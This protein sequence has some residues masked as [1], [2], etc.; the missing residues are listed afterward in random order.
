MTD[1]RGSSGAEKKKAGKPKGALSVRY[2]TPKEMKTAWE[3]ES[4]TLAELWDLHPTTSRPLLPGEVKEIQK[5]EVCRRFDPNNH[6]ML[7]A[8]R[9]ERIVGIAWFGFERTPVFGFYTGFLY[10]LAVIPEE[11]GRGVGRRLLEEVKRR[12]KKGG[13]K[14]LRLGVL[15]QNSRAM[16]LY[17][18]AGF[19]DETHLMIARLEP[20]GPE[21]AKAEA[22]IRKNAI[23]V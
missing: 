7:L 11:R 13:A 15:H 14:W 21:K 12:S 9:N 4:L 17:R 8:L 5:R 6:R 1:L 20:T 16:N 18:S 19:V 22:A 3:I 10:S 2:A 23:K